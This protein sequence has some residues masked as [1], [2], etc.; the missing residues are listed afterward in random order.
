SCVPLRLQGKPLSLCTRRVQVPCLLVGC[1]ARH[2]PW[3]QHNNLSVN[4]APALDATC[5]G[6]TFSLFMPP[7]AATLVS[8]TFDQALLDLHCNNKRRDKRCTSTQE[9][10]HLALG[11]R[12]VHWNGRDTHPIV[13]AHGHSVAL[14]ARR[15]TDVA[16]SEVFASLTVEFNWPNFPLTM[17]HRRG[18]FLAV[19]TGVIYGQG[20][21]CPHVLNNNKAQTDMVTNS[22]F[23]HLASYAQR[24]SVGLA[25]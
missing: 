5:S 14:H 9:Q 16:A 3:S 1:C 20:M 19:S 13:D 17:H 24:R 23:N 15:P 21:D 22:Q 11:F 4:T 2:H 25:Q 18:A 8:S 10:G 6:A 12:L 7:T